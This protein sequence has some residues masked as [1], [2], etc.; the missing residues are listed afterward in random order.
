MSQFISQH[1]QNG[2]LQL[3]ITDTEF[4]KLTHGR[5]DPELFTSKLTQGLARLCFDYYAAFGEAPR[6]HFH[7]ELT[8]YLATKPEDERE[9]FVSL[10]T[11][12][13]E[14]SPPN[15]DYILRRVNDFVK[16]RT[17][18][19][20]LVKA[21]ELLADGRMDM[22]DNALYDMLQSGIPEEDAGLDYLRDYSDVVNREYEG[23]LM[24]TGISALT[25]LIGG[26][27]RGQL[28][29]CLGA[30]KAGKSWWIAHT[31][32][33]AVIRGLNVAHLSFEVSQEEQETRY[34]MMF[35][36]RG[37][38]GVGESRRIMVW[39]EE[40][41]TPEER[42]IK[43]RSV[44]DPKAIIAAR[45]RV[46]RTGGSLR[47]KKYPQ[48]SCTPAEVER[49]LNYL[50]AHEDWTADVIL[51]DYPDLMDLSQYGTELRH[52]LNGAY[53]WAKGLADRRNV[54]VVAVSQV[55][56]EAMDK[57]VVRAKD[58]A[59]DVRK[60]A[61]CDIMLAIGRGPEEMKT[62]LAGINVLLNRSG[63]QD[64]NCTV[65]MCLDVGQFAI[66]SWIGSD[67]DKKI[68][69]AFNGESSDKSKD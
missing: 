36:C 13:N 40:R 67:T 38:K 58:V 29:V 28:V 6:D 52:Q 61:N 37:T 42:S 10:V 46:L 50:E 17:R 30:P 5:V 41:E 8:A 12:L 44:Y 15:R 56:R 49:Y 55:K 59:E 3:L 14:Q 62:G 22:A 43:I 33:A 21:A 16:S 48:G 68:M 18:E 64:S 53:I 63:H 35:S 34:D 66:S 60:A 20:T 57:R 31:G 19:L 51:L 1:L 45:K 23:Y 27:K 39:N 25:R 54:L 32:K 7:D 11:R 47:I 2:F 26:Y 24:P 9:M 69:E 65:S 4:C